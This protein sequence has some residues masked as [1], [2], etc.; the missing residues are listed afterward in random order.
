MKLTDH[1]FCSMCVRS[2][3]FQ[4]KDSGRYNTRTGNRIFYAKLVCPIY[5]DGEMNLRT[6]RKFFS[7]VDW[8]YHTDVLLPENVKV[9]TETN[10]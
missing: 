3:I 8:Q 6:W 5:L 9:A 1:K 10:L 2:L 4:R 7:L